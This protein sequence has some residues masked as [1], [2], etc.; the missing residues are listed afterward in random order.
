MT[1]TIEREV[2]GTSS[3][4]FNCACNKL[5][6]TTGVRCVAVMVIDGADSPDYSVMRPLDAQLPLPDLVEKRAA[7]L[8]QHS[9]INLQCTSGSATHAPAPNQ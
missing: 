3:G 4:V 5:P 8:R 2:E 6:D 9:A 7:A 1:D